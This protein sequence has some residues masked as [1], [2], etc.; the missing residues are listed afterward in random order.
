[1][2][3]LTPPVEADLVPVSETVFAAKSSGSSSDWMPVVFSSLPDGTG[4][5]YVGMRAAPKDR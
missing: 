5:C 3:G 2:K 4:C 1:M